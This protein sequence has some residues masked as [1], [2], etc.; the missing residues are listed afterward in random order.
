MK[1]FKEFINEGDDDYKGTHTAPNK[2]FGAPLHNVSSNEMYPSNVYSDKAAHLYG[3]GDSVNDRAVINKIHSLR[4]KPES[5]VDV[6]R[7]VPKDAPDKINHGD[8]VTIHKPYAQQHGKSVLN[9]NYKII[10]EKHPAK[11]LYTNA[12]SIYEFGLDKR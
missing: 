10:H 3:V 1:S 8:W 12:D 2:D 5:M 9:N 6:Y 4:N 11:H 7:A